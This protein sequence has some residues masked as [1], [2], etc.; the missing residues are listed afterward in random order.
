[1]LSIHMRFVERLEWLSSDVTMEHC[2]AHFIPPLFGS[3]LFCFTV[4]L[5]KLNFGFWNIFLR[6]IMMA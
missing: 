5:K 6:T 3:S 2:N 1:M 4:F